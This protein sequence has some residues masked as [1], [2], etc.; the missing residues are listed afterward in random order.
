MANL[1]ASQLLSQLVI[2]DM[3]AKLASVMPADALQSVVK[4]CGILAQAAQLLTVPAIV[5]EQYPQG[6][7][8]TLAEIK[9]FLAENKPIAKTVFSACN[10]P[11]FNQQL[12]RDKPQIILAGMEAHICV[13]QTALALHQAGKQVFVVEDAIISRK[14]A[15]KANALARMRDV[16]CVI[17]NTESVVFEWLENANHEAFKAISKLIR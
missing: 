12:H 8:E 13:L 5:T 1:S 3:Q 2:I 6:L 15:N 16:G 17:T 11:K 9:Q 7:G 10:E 14:P 4:N